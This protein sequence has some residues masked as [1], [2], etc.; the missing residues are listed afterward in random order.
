M[1]SE[2]AVPRSTFVTVVAWIFI[3]L[4]GFSTLIAI[5]QNVMFAF[6]FPMHEMK[7]PE[8]DPR[9]G[10]ETP[11]LLLFFFDHIQLLFVG[12]LA[13]S[14]A[15]F[16]A[17][18]G[19]LKRKNWARLLFMALMALGIAWNAA[20]LLLLIPFH[21]MVSGATMA[22]NQP[23]LPRGFETMWTVMVVINTL[24]VAGFIWL[25]AWIIKRLASEPVRREFA[26][27]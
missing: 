6:V 18:V 5:L 16:V 8:I 7:L 9:T 22:A 25:F 4:A 21:S 10:K 12:F 19:L 17:A 23:G 1:A 2:P 15:T 24:I 26:E 14:A 11:A 20:G 13:A 27:R 3:V